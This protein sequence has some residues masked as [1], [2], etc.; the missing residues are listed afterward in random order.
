MDDKPQTDKK[1]VRCPKCMVEMIWN[2]SNPYRPFCSERCK[3][4]DFICWTQ[5]EHHI[6][7]QAAYDDV[8]SGE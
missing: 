5:E 7:G 4:K 6:P 3:N 1:N 8:F 2:K